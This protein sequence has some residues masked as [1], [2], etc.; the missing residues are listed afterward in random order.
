MC[1]VAGLPASFTYREVLGLCSYFGGVKSV[2]R[3]RKDLKTATPDS[4]SGS[5]AGGADAAAAGHD[6]ARDEAE[7]ARL[8]QPSFVLF[9]SARSAA[10]AVSALNGRTVQGCKVAAAFA[11]PKKAPNKRKAKSAEKKQET[12]DDSKAE[13]PSS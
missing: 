2:V 4:S 9:E 8:G 3:M 6:T 10:A 12:Q 5:A 13:E 11:T 1:C 7:M